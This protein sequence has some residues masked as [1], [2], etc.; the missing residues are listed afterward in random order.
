M[1][2]NTHQY[3]MKRTSVSGRLANTTDPANT[4]YIPAGGLAVNFADRIVYTSDGA[5]LFP[6]GTPT[7]S[8]LSLNVLTANVIHTT[9]V[10]SN[11]DINIISNNYVQ[12]MYNPNNQVGASET[13]NTAWLY[14]TSGAIISEAYDS[15]GAITSAQY[16][17]YN[18][19][20]STAIVASTNNWIFGANG[21]LYYP[22]GTF[23]SGGTIIAPNNYD[24][25][26]IGATYIQT[27]A[28]AGAKTW[29][30]DISGN[31]TFPD[32]TVQSTAFMGDANT[33]SNTS[34]TQIKGYITGNSA[35][36]YTN[37]VS[38]TDTKIGLVNTA[39]VANASAS[40]ANAVAYAA[41][42]YTNALSYAN[43]AAHNAYVN[44]TSY[45][46]T[47][48]YNAYANSITV[49]S[50]GLSN[51]TYV[52][53]NATYAANSG[54]LG[55]Q[56]LS[57]IQS[58]ITGNS[59]TAYSNAVATAATDASTKAA[60][61][62]SNAVA[63][64]SNVVTNGAITVSNATYSSNS[65]ALGGK[66]LAT[67]ES[68]ITGNAATAYANA[69]ANAAALYQ[70]TAGL[71]ANVLKL[72]ANS[73]NFIG[74]L[75][76]ANVVSNA[77]LQSNLANYAALSGATF[78]GVVNAA[79]NV[80]ISGSVAI[81]GNLTIAGQTTFVNTTVISTSDKIIY[82]AANSGD[83]TLSDGSGIVVTNAASWTYND[84]TFSF[85][86][87]VNI[88]PSG[89]S[90]LNLGATG[91]YWNIV[92]ANQV[93]G[94]L[95]TT[96]QPNITANNSTYFGGVSLGTVN[97]A[98][99]ANASA[100]YTNAVS[101]ATTLAGTA[102][103]NSVNYVANGVTNGSI[104][105]ANATYAANSGLLG[106]L[107]LTTIQ[108]QITGNAATAYTNAVATASADATSKA[109]TAY[110]NAVT[111]ATALAG[112]AYTNAVA[113]AA[114]D[115]SSKA[116]TAYSNAVTYAASIANTAYTNAVATAAT[117]AT[118]K[119]GNAY[120]N[121]VST[122]ATDATNKAGNAYSNAVATAA[123]D[124]TNKAGN[125][126]SN[127]VSQA[128]T[129]AATAYSNA[130]ANAAAIYQTTAGLSANVVTLTSNSANFIGTLPAANVVSNAQL[131]GNLANYTNNASLVLAQ[132][133]DTAANGA[134]S[135]QVLTYS[136]ALSKWIN[137]NP[138]VAN[139]I[140]TTG[141][142]GSFYDTSPTQNT[143][144]S[145]T[146]TVVKIGSTYIN[147]GVTV[148]SNGHINIAYAGTYQIE[149]SLQF[150]STN[151]GNDTIYVWLR[152]NGTDIV[153]STSTFGIY[154]VSGPTN[155]Y[156]IALTPFVDN[157]NAGDYYQIMW[158][159][160]STGVN[161]YTS[162]PSFAPVTPAVIVG[163]FPVSNIITAP[164]GSNTQV[165][166]NDSGIT[167]ASAGFTF[168]RTSN[169]LF[170]T[171]NMFVTNT[172]NAASFTVDK[173]FVANTSSVTIGNSTAVGLL[174][175]GNAGGNVVINS[176]A[177]SI[178]A[179][180]INSTSYTG[181]AN[182]ATYLAN[183]SGTLT[184]IQSWITGNSATAYANAVANAAAL[185]QTTAGLSANV[186]ILTANAAGF[187][188]NSSGTIANVASWIT[189]NSATAYSN[190]T[191]FA[192]NASNINT[193]T[194]SAARLGSGT[195][196]ST[197]ILYGNGV[198]AA[199][200]SSVN[201]AAAYTWTNTQT[202]NAQVNLGTNNT[203]LTF[204]ANDSA[205]GNL[206]YF[207]LQNDNNFVF[208]NTATDGSS[209]AIWASFTNSN[210][211]SFNV[212]VPLK[213]SSALQDG[214]GS[215]GSSGYI[216][217]SNG[218]GVNW[219]SQGAASVNTFAQFTWSN[220]HTFNANVTF[221]NNI[222]IPNGNSIYFNGLSD[223]NWRIGRDTS[224]FTKAY[225]T[226]N[227]I[228]IISAASSLEGI[229]LGQV[230]N[231]SY[232]ETGYAGSW[233]RANVA[234]GNVAWNSM[235]T[236]NG[237][238]TF[239]NST[240]NTL[241]IYAN[242]QII[243]PVFTGNLTGTATNASALGSVSLSTLQSQITGNAATAYSNATAYADGAAATAYAN[244][245]ANA[246]A[247]YQTSA[248]LAAN[249]M[250]LASNL[251]SFL[252]NSSGTLG[253]IQSYITGNSATA[254]SNATAYA[255]SKAATAYANA[256]ANAA[257]LYQTTAD[258]SANVLTLTANAANYLGNSTGTFTNIVSYITGNAATAYTNAVNYVANGV[259]NGA[260][261]AA[262][263]TY[264][265]NT[266]AL[267]SVTLAT[268]QGQI[269]G[270]A[271]TAYSNA[272]ANTTYQAGVAY[273]NAVN[274]VA[275]G[276]TN[277]A[278]VAA[279]ATLFAGQPASYYTNATNINTGTLPYAQLPA[280]V[281]ISSNNTTITGTTTYNANLTVS[282]ANSASVFQVGNS[283][284]NVIMWYDVANSSI[285]QFGGNVNNFLQITHTNL[286]TGNNASTDFSLYDTNGI[287]GSNYID[288][289][290]AGNAYANAA[291]TI[292]NPSDGYVYTVNSN[293]A[294]GVA[295]SN[296]INFFAGGSLLANK[297]MVLNST[298]LALSNNIS[299]IANGSNGTSGQVLT[300]NGTGV[301][302]SS[303]FSGTANNSTN[304]G[305]LSLTTVQGQI[306]G[307]SATA[308]TNAT[309]YASN[310]TN[311][312]SGTVGTARLGSGTAN[313]TTILYGNG[314][315]AAAPSSVNTAASYTW[316]NTQT[317][318]ANVTIGN[319][320]ALIA[321][322]S[323]GSNGQVL[324]SNGTGL[325]WN[326][327]TASSTRV[328][329]YANS[330][331]FTVNTDSTDIAT[332]VYTGTS[333]TFT[334]ANTTGTPS[335]GQK[336]MFR[337]QTTNSQTLSFQA[338]FAGS[339]DLALPTALSGSN[340]Y[341]YL[342]FIYNSTSSTW[343]LL[344]KNFGF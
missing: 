93:Y 98:I 211:S 223:G 183:S 7:G 329:S 73:A 53:A 39:I 181:S 49:I 36:A 292:L 252:S 281:M 42:V 83:H 184:N 157:A 135:G 78:T 169:S 50:T 305:G 327:P 202:F 127:A 137:A 278:I 136:T 227:T 107:S 257:A 117:D 256:A 86:S 302:W 217:Q 170:V 161:M 59:A 72:T 237:T 322:G 87:N 178:G 264:S 194:V 121:A 134:T 162:S 46:N 139:T 62:Y 233:F 243:A 111:Q 34:L 113:T 247:I 332:M 47:A 209:R 101:Q 80:N 114:T 205:S 311:L 96:S 276:V 221:G 123:T 280:N 2:G 319:T 63:Y 219:I 41:N 244:A 234:I 44:A 330:S 5:N 14:V 91:L 69:V 188:G 175:V 55:G 147:N 9:N 31:I 271:A 214:T 164:P 340:K 334:I 174:N 166:F 324:T 173:F 109:A 84:P 60:T 155:G 163:V 259:T 25:Q 269:T 248:G 201:T 240:A 141:Y 208:Y 149:Y 336:L 140:Y 23:T 287:T 1:A 35:T 226:N 138:P 222:S 310:A 246:A 274:Y 57:T 88:T 230:G 265:S 94:T 238:I 71:S 129:L 215:N 285:A 74:T 99:T 54:A 168:D 254:Y 317:F 22:D 268:L 105:A 128:T 82:L 32:N 38:Y 190:A 277:G 300:S 95:M 143:S 75:P 313:S 341:D 283:S 145:N 67:V 213:I 224:S 21:N 77:Q 250:V 282:G 66:T 172:V 236:V 24:I 266:G 154:G 272:V 303:S 51:G 100:A 288:I 89:N 273:T 270:N 206:S 152:K 130:V 106:G 17:G 210:T 112:N 120:S 289:G 342:G 333:G 151:N 133:N 304:F 323:A 212:V 199:A 150:Q 48:A 315:W 306:T 70:T 309:S 180:T 85:Q 301:Y 198:W 255:D 325:F 245:V 104:V 68:E 260:I 10:I 153:D 45:A 4:A 207:I 299:L 76:A 335:N 204:A 159:A 177:I 197:T 15:N 58:Y 176:T 65:G 27:S 92:Y 258:L 242:G 43:T 146:A 328:V 110:S 316:T 182:A 249:V 297:V 239:A 338:Q 191:V 8:N 64:I 26:S 308:Y 97:S 326:T 119:A 298:S 108:G 320:A 37:A 337:I 331:T 165:L 158:A 235:L 18:G 185:Y 193:G 29:T 30:F 192:S 261:V 286:N 229:A 125:A 28:A 131:Q 187:L 203:K 124:A 144:A 231:T 296:N 11:N 122:A 142:Y 116:A 148:G 186:A 294:I 343:Q 40:Y 118:N 90:T 102:Y 251:A 103:T 6:I 275:N 344:A 284:G 132:L 195:A 241:N 126:Y 16:I 295:G 228:D 290:I 293:F 267:G 291:W 12:I 225:Y 312:S 216:L 19:T 33:L 318:S 339:T 3:Q 253:N 232:F 56:P 115:A 79:A 196:N 81:S 262:N 160:S 200:P 314:V 220:T 279:N 156:I 189:G 20:N 179:A 13:I 61:A 218:T 263:A 307:N 171:N 321:N 167:N 52:S